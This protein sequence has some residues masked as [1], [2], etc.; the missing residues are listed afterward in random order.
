M[1]SIRKDLKIDLIASIIAII[2]FLFSVPRLIKKS[3]PTTTAF[4]GICV[5]LLLIFNL[6]KIHSKN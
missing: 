4:L 1:K 2:I 5:I 6:I 3:D